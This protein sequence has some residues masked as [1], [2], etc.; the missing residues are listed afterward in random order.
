MAP[1]EKPKGKANEKKKRSDQ[2]YPNR[3]EKIKP[4]TV[5]KS[6]VGD[7][8]LVVLTDEELL[9][10][11]GSP[12]V[13]AEQIRQRAELGFMYIP[14]R[15]PQENKPARYQDVTSWPARRLAPETQGAVWLGN[16]RSGVMDHR[17]DLLD[18]VPPE[19]NGRGQFYYWG[20]DE[21]HRLLFSSIDIHVLGD[22]AQGLIHRWELHFENVQHLRT[23]LRNCQMTQGAWM[24]VEDVL[25]KIR[26]IGDVNPS[27]YVEAG[28]SGHAGAYAQ[29]IMTSS[30]SGL[31]LAIQ[32][33]GSV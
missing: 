29:K 17:Y 25:S 15:I 9:E 24:E 10:D 23:L 16:Q 4:S 8:E 12:P 20:Q 30:N 6:F 21:R 32:L 7:D 1:K 26:R 14:P 27:I 22:R 3:N 13:T 33:L 11:T 2:W 18:G 19:R 5:A 28:G 31:A